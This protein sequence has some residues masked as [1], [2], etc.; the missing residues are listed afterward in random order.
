VNHACHIPNK[1]LD[2]RLLWTVLLGAE[3]YAVFQQLNEYLTRKG[4][5]VHFSKGSPTSQ[6][7]QAYIL[8]IDA[9]SYTRID[10]HDAKM[11]TALVF[12][13]YQ[14]SVKSQCPCC[15]HITWKKRKPYKKPHFHRIGQR[16]LPWQT[17]TT[18]FIFSNTFE[19]R[20]WMNM[21]TLLVMG[22]SV[23]NS[24]ILEQTVLA[25]S[26]TRRLTI[27]LDSPASSAS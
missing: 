15:D 19:H 9:G 13:K 20:F 8:K 11:K 2:E 4:L 3:E 21:A 27:G 18:H 23:V 6:P 22:C 7:T 5:V 10:L 24:G 17:D 12:Q 14:P 26:C 25:N 1:R 16:R